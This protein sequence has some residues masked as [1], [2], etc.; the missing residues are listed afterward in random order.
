VILDEK[1]REIFYRRDPF[2]RKMSTQREIEKCWM[3]KIRRSRKTYREILD[4]RYGEP[5]RKFMKDIGKS[6]KRYR[7]IQ[8]T[9]RDILGVRYR[10]IQE[11]Y[12][13]F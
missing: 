9:Y 11:R 7:E 2:S 8:E 1:F 12:G 6:W 5:C 13:E 3:K 10:E 4:E